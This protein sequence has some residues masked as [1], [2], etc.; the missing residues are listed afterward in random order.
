MRNRVIAWGTGL[1]LLIAA[2]TAETITMPQESKEVHAQETVDDTRLGVVSVVNTAS[3]EESVSDEI[4]FSEAEIMLMARVAQAEYG[5]GE[6]IDKRLVVSVILN[7]LESDLSDFKHLTTVESVVNQP[8][9][10][11]VAA[12]NRVTLETLNCVYKEI[13]ERT[14]YRVLWFKTGGYPSWGEPIMKVN[15][16]YFSGVK[17]E[18]GE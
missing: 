3:A 12:Q 2:C 10:F 17:G 8:N 18:Q 9:Q 6:E 11:A 14:D 16:H 1:L 7:R 4:P 5:N 13:R 15:S